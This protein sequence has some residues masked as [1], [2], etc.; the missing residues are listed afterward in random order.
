MAN[1]DARS[2]ED[3]RDLQAVV[4]DAERRGWAGKVE[5][6]VRR[7]VQAK[8]LTESAGTAG[9]QG[10]RRICR[11]TTIAGHAGETGKRV[12]RADE[13]AA[14]AA[15]GLTGDVHAEVHAVDGI[16]VAV[17]GQAEKHL[18]AGRGPAKAVRSRIRGRVVWTEVCL[19]LD[20]AA[21]KHTMAGA[22]NQS[23]A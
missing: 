18:I 8:S 23:L 10:G 1:A 21:G 6:V 4:E 20:D 9:K 11:H 22:V 5:P 2:D 13:D 16:Y 3:W 19:D 12:K 7:A 17:S 14:G 15:L